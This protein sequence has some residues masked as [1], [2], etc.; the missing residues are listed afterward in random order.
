MPFCGLPKCASGMIAPE[1]Y[2]QPG[3]PIAWTMVR[4]PL[5]RWLDAI[6]TDLPRW[7]ELW[8]WC[9]RF[10]QP[11]V[12]AW[13]IQQIITDQVKDHAQLQYT[14]LL[15]DYQWEEVELWPIHQYETARREQGARWSPFTRTNPS[16]QPWLIRTE[17]M[18]KIQDWVN[19]IDPWHQ[20]LDQWSQVYARDCQLW[21]RVESHWVEHSE[22]LVLTR[23]EMQSRRT[24][25]PLQPR[26]WDDLQQILKGGE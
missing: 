9:K 4:D 10:N 15:Q 8:A 26:T 13:D 2:H 20:V 25:Q 18:V 5:E 17:V 21:D 6:T 12:T 22:P 3:D 16:Y 24:W 1:D 14:V 7:Q 11:E 19:R 23:K